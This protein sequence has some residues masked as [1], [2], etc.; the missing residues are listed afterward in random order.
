MRI[1]RNNRG[2]ATSNRDGSY[3]DSAYR[4]G[5]MRTDRNN[6]GQ[7][8]NNRDGSY[9]D[10]ADRD[11][12]TGSQ[13]D[14]YNDN[15]GIAGR[16]YAQEIGLFDG[17]HGFSPENPYY[18][19]MTNATNKKDLEG[20]RQAALEW[21][22]NQQNYQQQ[23]AD[24]R[25][26][27]DEDRLYNSPAQQ[28]ARER[29]AGLNPDLQGGTAYSGSSSSGGSVSVPQ[30]AETEVSN[31]SDSYATADRVFA[32]MNATASLLSSVSSF[33][34]GGVDFVKSIST[35]GDVLSMSD[36]GARVAQTQANIAEQTQGAEISNANVEAANRRLVLA[37]DFAGSLSGDE[38]EDQVRELAMSYLPTDDSFADEVL[39]FQ[40]NPGQQKRYQD[41]KL[42][43]RKSQA[44]K[45]AAPYD[46]LL[47]TYEQSFIAQSYAAEAE[48]A[49][50]HLNA[51][52]SDALN[53][54]D[55]AENI[56]VSELEGNAL[57]AQQ[58]QFDVKKFERAKQIY[59]DTLDYFVQ[60]D[61]ALRQEL[62][63]LSN[64]HQGPDRRQLI[65]ALNLRRY[66][67]RSVGNEHL[68]NGFNILNGIYALESTDQYLVGGQYDPLISGTPTAKARRK[69]TAWL[70]DTYSHDENGEQK[71]VLSKFFDR[72]LDILRL[73][74]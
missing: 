23:L 20:L 45:D 24:Q 14:F 65:K 2:Q 50:Q 30:M 16:N 18:Q 49:S 6:R 52:V 42:E 57:S 29:A 47:S 19:Q 74:K 43:A 40:S 37:G 60:E 22:S 71:G 63:R 32:G 48:A 1:Y 27:R 9:N 8:T 5:L 10:P 34:T 46:L 68:H 13:A 61:K 67:L 12:L 51:I 41:L 69:Y 58:K 73:A 56:V 31:L 4:D 15:L 35:L 3:N 7:A 39:R 54:L 70:F 62:D 28:I 36:A 17:T 21:E 72:A 59:F 44:R 25:A 33:A 55:N 11:V 64:E 26:L 53:S 66:A 38:S